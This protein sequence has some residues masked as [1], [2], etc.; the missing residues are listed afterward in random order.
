MLLVFEN[1]SN[2]SLTLW[3]SVDIALIIIM[4]R[5]WL[6]VEILTITNVCQICFNLED[7]IDINSLESGIS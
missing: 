2:S 4:F 1:V 6:A 5:L 7:I 3:I